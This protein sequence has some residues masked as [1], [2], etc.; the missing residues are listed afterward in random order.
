MIILIMIV[1]IIMI[2]IISIIM[3][4][5]MEL[6]GCQRHDLTATTPIA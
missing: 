5:A 4:P 6:F 1:M 3:I 2:I